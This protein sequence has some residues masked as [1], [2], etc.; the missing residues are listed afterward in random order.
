MVAQWIGTE[1]KNS[2]KWLS[3]VTRSNRHLFFEKLKNAPVPI[4]SPT[5]VKKKPNIN[6]AEK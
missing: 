5:N 6:H 4:L 1:S 3:S 2:F